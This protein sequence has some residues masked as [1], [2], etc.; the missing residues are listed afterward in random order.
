MSGI[1]RRQLEIS[2]NFW[3]F[4]GISRNFRSKNEISR[5]SKKMEFQEQ[6]RNFRNFDIKK[7]ISQISKNF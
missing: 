4:I 2:R 7:G 5:I 1:F 6:K 3:E